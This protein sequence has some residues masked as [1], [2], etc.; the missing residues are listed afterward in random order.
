MCLTLSPLSRFLVSQ[1]YVL[2]GCSF[3]LIN[4]VFLASVNSFL[5]H[6]IYEVCA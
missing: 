6:F 4:I 5:L 1:L 3:Y 2:V